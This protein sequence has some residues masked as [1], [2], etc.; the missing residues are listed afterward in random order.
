MYYKCLIKTSFFFN[1]TRVLLVNKILKVLIFCFQAGPGWWFAPSCFVFI[2]TNISTQFLLQSVCACVCVCV[3]VCVCSAF[4]G[5][6]F[7][8]LYVD[9]FGR[10]MLYMCLEYHI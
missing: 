10:T 8:I 1:I 2:L 7:I 9:Y 3:C 5:G 6:V 4:F